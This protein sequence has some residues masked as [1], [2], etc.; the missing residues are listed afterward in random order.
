MKLTS[1]GSAAMLYGIEAVLAAESGEGDDELLGRV[2]FADEGRVEMGNAF[3]SELDGRLYTPLEELD[4]GSLLT[5]EER[6][7]LRTQASRILPDSE[8]WTIAIDGLTSAKQ[9]IKIEEFRAREKAL[10]LHL[11]ECAG[12]TRAAHFF[13]ISVGDWAGVPIAEVLQGWKPPPSATRVLI[14]GFDQYAASSVTSVAGASWIFRFE[15]LTSAGAFLATKLDGKPLSRDHGAPV[16]LV[17]P[18]WYGCTCIKW[19][20]RIMF[21]DDA[22]EATSQMTEYAVRTHQNGNPHLAKDFLPARIEHAAMPIRVE[23]L[24]TNGK[25]KYRVVGLLWGG[26]GTVSKL[27]IRFNPEEEYVPVESLRIPHTTSWTLW[28]HTWTPAQRGRYTIRLS[29]LEPKEKPKRLDA[30]YYARTVE[31]DEI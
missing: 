29:I 27:G 17:V 9:S 31:I 28:S 6:F 4:E 15:E 8:G 3:G 7:Y 13:M 24:R 10:G 14:S 19:V 1:I 2:G 11:M 30:G 26:H 5:P 16:R 18:G 21:V 23:K 22:A 20:D 12:N 25:L